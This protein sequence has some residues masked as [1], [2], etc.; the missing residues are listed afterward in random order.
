MNPTD[1]FKTAE[2]L[3]NETEQAHIRSSISRSYYGV[4]LYFRK[5]LNDNGIKKKDKRDVHFFVFKCLEQ[6]KAV[7]GE[8][9]AV[10]LYNLR[11]DR[12]I[13]DYDLTKNVKNTKSND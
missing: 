4:F 5:F 10:R 6:S 8:T 1:F 2:L 11:G 3:K 9:V 13:A 12:S 7:I